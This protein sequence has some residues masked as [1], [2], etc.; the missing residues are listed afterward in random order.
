[1]N[2]KIKSIPV[3]AALLPVLGFC[4]SC[5]TLN[6]PPPADLSAPGW[7]SLPGQAV[8]KPAADRPELTGDLLLATNVNGDFFVQFTKSPFPL[9]TAESI[10][11]QWQIEFGA[12]EHVWRGRGRPPSRFAW[13]QLPVA[14]LDGKTGGHWSFESGTA[15]SAGSWRL[16]NRQTGE[17][18]EGGFFP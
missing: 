7:H 12:D 5:R 1:M 16:E 18:L 3:L 4:V 14:L 15:G 17:S 9:V 10:G 8:W 13:F 2:R 11:G 6:P